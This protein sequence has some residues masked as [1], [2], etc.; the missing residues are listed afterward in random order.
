MTVYGEWVYS[1][2]YFLLLH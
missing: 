1:D 2:T